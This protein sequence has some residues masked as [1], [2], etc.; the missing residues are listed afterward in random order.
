VQQE[1]ISVFPFLKTTVIDTVR[2][3]P[4]PDLASDIA[5]FSIG[6]DLGPFSGRI[7]MLLQGETLSYVGVREELDGFTDTYVRWDMT[8]TY[9]ITKNIEIYSNVNNLTNRPDESFMQT[10]RYPTSREF[11]GWTGDVGIAVKF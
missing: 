8:L 7:S 11:Y 1:R 10:A 6:Y 2:V 5:N 9:D 4:M 3:G